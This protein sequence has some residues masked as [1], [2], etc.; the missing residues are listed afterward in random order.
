M[1]DSFTC[2]TSLFAECKEPADP[3]TLT[4]G[5]CEAD[6][7]S[8]VR[9]VCEPSGCDTGRWE[10][11]QCEESGLRA[12]RTLFTMLPSEIL[13]KSGRR[14]GKQAA[15]TPK[16][17]SIIHQNIIVLRVAYEQSAALLNLSIQRDTNGQDQHARL[18]HRL[19]SHRF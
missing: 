12:L 14:V 4:I 6:E 7:F 11:C 2:V 5:I 3:V 15:M 9:L 19:S 18:S 1:P 10:R 8:G 16:P 13:L 17:A